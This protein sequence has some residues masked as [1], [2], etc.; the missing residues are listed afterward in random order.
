[1]A[2]EQAASLSMHSYIHSV[3]FKNEATYIHKFETSTACS[4]RNPPI[5]EFVRELYPL[6]IR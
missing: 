1:M 6:R 3:L 2:S 4:D 5:Q